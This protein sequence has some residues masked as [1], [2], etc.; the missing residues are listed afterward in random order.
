M[1]FVKNTLDRQSLR[2][3]DLTFLNDRIG[4]PD[5]EVILSTAHRLVF[6]SSRAGALGH[7]PKKAFAL[8]AQ[9]HE[10]VFLGQNHDGSRPLFAGLLPMSDEEVD[11]DDSLWANDLRNIA[12]QSIFSEQDLSALSQARALL[13]WH[14]THGFCSRCGKPSEIADAGYRRDCKFCGGQHFPRTDPCVIM[15]ITDGD[16]ALFGRPPRLP[17]GIYTTLAGFME[18]GET[19]EQAVRRE[20]LEEAGI[21][22]GE[23]RIISNQPWPFPANLMIGCIGKAES[24]E[25]HIEDDELEACRWCDRAEVRKMLEGTHSDGDRIPPSISIAYK[26]IAG[27]LEGDF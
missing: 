9:R 6:D 10:L 12:L 7:P 22:V 16:R 15:L 21:D 26:L 25:I 20:T 24:T 23:V 5:C 11:A 18:P 14:R 4:Q 17:D 8:G 27:W 2:R 13:H 1:S 19:V 3:K